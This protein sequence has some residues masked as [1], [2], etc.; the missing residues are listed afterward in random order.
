MQALFL[1][2]FTCLTTYAPYSSGQRLTLAIPFPIVKAD[3]W[4]L[5]NVW[6]PPNW[7]FMCV[8]SSSVR[9][10]ESS[11]KWTGDPH[12]QPLKWV[13]LNLRSHFLS[14][15][16]PAFSNCYKYSNTPGPVKPSSI[17]STYLINVT[18]T[19]LQQP[20]LKVLLIHF[21]FN[22][23]KLTRFHLHFVQSIYG[24]TS[25]QTPLST[26]T[27]SSCNYASHEIRWS[28][29]TSVPLLYTTPSTCLRWSVL[30]LDEGLVKG[31]FQLNK[32]WNGHKTTHKLRLPFG[33]RSFQ[34]VDFD[35]VAEISANWKNIG[36]VLVVFGDSDSAFVFVGG[37]VVEFGKEVEWA[38][39]EEK[40]WGVASGME[41]VR[42]L[43][44]CL[45]GGLGDLVDLRKINQNVS[46]S[47]VKSFI[48][49]Y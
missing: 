49:F 20:T 19:I 12:F 24:W 43:S 27:V 41:R 25:L 39:G 16:S 31:S 5:R 33:G 42:W 48:E 37:Q 29:W 40:E 26:Q 14:T 45:E 4:F 2:L 32:S 17:N 21:T 15:I 28:V 11:D 47:L 38:A 9:C 1:K 30:D 18:L 13:N 46:K 10:L 23:W 44:G 8:F 34:L 6:R 22:L 35:V 3:W 36:K 7:D